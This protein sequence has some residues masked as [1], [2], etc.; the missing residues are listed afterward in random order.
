MRWWKKLRSHYF[1]SVYFFWYGV[2]VIKILFNLKEEN[3][4]LSIGSFLLVYFLIF[5][6]EIL[7]VFHEI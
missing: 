6:S 2:I 3:S 4:W 7:K 5:Q 1:F